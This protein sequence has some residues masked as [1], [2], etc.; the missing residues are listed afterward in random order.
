[1][2]RKYLL[3]GA[4][5]IEGHDFMQIMLPISSFYYMRSEKSFDLTTSRLR[6]FSVAEYKIMF[7][8]DALSFGNKIHSVSKTIKLILAARVTEENVFLKFQVFRRTVLL[9]I[10]LP[11]TCLT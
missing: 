7:D 11:H 9:E 6:I 8:I 5:I 3:L 4:D 10:P 1:M 2:V